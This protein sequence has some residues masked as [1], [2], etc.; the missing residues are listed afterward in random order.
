MEWRDIPS[1]PAGAGGA[2][3]PCLLA[4][5]L[6]DNDRPPDR[7]LILCFLLPG[8]SLI[9]PDF[10]SAVALPSFLRFFAVMPATEG[11]DGEGSEDEICWRFSGG[12]LSF[13][14]LFLSVPTGNVLVPSFGAWLFFGFFLDSAPDSI[15]ERF[16]DP[17]RLSFGPAVGRGVDVPGACVAFLDTTGLAVFVSEGAAAGVEGVAAAAAAVAAAGVVVAAFAAAA[18]AAFSAAF[19]ATNF[20]SASFSAASTFLASSAFL[21]SS[22]LRASSSSSSESSSY[23]RTGVSNSAIEYRGSIS[24]Y[25]GRNDILSKRMDLRRSPFRMCSYPHGS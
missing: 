24:N 6:G 10:S 9:S 17:E 14:I 23:S 5:A 13:T 11:G 21:A 20:S 25:I 8:P 3:L 16:G 22:C 15:P 2:G 12:T 7:S 1:A 19:S 4:A 18:A